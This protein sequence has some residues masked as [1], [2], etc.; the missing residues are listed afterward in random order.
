MGQTEM[1]KL[2]G[3]VKAARA[4]VAAKDM[5]GLKTA[6]MM[7]GRGRQTR[8]TIN[9]PEG[10]REQLEMMADELGVSMACLLR[11]LAVEAYAQWRD[12]DSLSVQAK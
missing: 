3:D 4:A 2:K 12:E 10:E 11:S 7:G 1:D 6:L 8:L 9:I 5:R